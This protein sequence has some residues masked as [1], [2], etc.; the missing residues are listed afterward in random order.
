MPSHVSITTAVG[1]FVEGAG[2]HRAVFEPLWRDDPTADA[3]FAGGRDRPLLGCVA[4]AYGALFYLRAADKHAA[5]SRG[6][7]VGGASEG[8]FFDGDQPPA[9]RVARIRQEIIGGALGPLKSLLASQD[10]ARYGRWTILVA[11]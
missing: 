11:D 9:D 5:A 6:P 8:A 1:V 4:N 3:L 2:A 10:P 7:V